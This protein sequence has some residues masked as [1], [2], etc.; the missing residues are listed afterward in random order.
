VARENLLQTEFIGGRWCVQ[1]SAPPELYTFKGGYVS[2]CSA[3]TA[4]AIGACADRLPYDLLPLEAAALRSAE[5]RAKADARPVSVDLD[6]FYRCG[7]C[8]RLIE[9]KAARYP[10]APVGFGILPHCR[11]CYDKATAGVIAP[12]T[13]D[14]IARQVNEAQAATAATAESFRGAPIVGGLCSDC[15]RQGD[16]FAFDHDFVMGCPHCT[17]TQLGHHVASSRRFG[18][19]QLIRE[20][21]KELAARADPAWRP[22]SGTG[23]ATRCRCSASDI[24]LSAAARAFMYGRQG[25]RPPHCMVCAGIRP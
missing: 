10:R 20:M 17:V 18:A 1:C 15:G 6:T 25:G 12:A 19:F 7:V 11:D 13:S 14:R 4:T 16:T 24:V 3:C 5:D 22:P 23:D 2:I 8:N 21:K 9:H